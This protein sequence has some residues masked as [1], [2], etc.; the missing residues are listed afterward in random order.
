MKKIAVIGSINMDLVTKVNRLPQPGETIRGNSFGNFPGGKGANQAVA[1]GRLGG[2]VSMVGKLEND[3]IAEEY[4][5]VF[6]NNS[7]NNERVILEKER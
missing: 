4:L 1:A 7:V 5:K 6:R 2:N 3:S